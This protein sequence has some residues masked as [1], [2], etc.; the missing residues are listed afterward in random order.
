MTYNNEQT[1]NHSFDLA[2]YKPEILL[3][4]NSLSCAYTAGAETFLNTILIGKKE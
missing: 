4:C 1:R 2:L 3:F